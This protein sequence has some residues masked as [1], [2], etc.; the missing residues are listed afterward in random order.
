MWGQYSIFY[1]V[2]FVDFF[3]EIWYNNIKEV[4]YREEDLFFEGGHLNTEKE[5][6]LV[7]PN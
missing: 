5:R 3:S 2:L 4:N 7:V 6:I 1:L